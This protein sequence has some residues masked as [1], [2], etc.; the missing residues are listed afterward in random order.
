MVQ[1]AAGPGLAS[2]AIPARHTDGP[3]AASLTP[4]FHCRTGASRQFFLCA[5]AHIFAAKHCAAWRRK[6]AAKVRHCKV[7]HRPHRVYKGSPQ[8]PAAKATGLGTYCFGFRDSFRRYTTGSVLN[9]LDTPYIVCARLK[10]GAAPTH[11][12]GAP[13]RTPPQTAHRRGHPCKLL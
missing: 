6:S 13:G 11:C 2:A 8:V 9:R 10:S 12:G 4:R 7:L 3:A 5:F 1:A